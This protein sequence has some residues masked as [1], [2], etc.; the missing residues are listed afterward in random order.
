VGSTIVAVAESLQSDFW[1]RLIFWQRCGTVSLT[2]V[3]THTTLSNS[4]ETAK[5]RVDVTEQGSLVFDR[6]TKEK[7]CSKPLR[8]KFYNL[9]ADSE[10]SASTPQSPP[11]VSEPAEEGPA[12][13][14]SMG[15]AVETLEEGVAIV[16]GVMGESLPVKTV[17]Q[18]GFLASRAADEGSNTASNGAAEASSGAVINGRWEPLVAS[19]VGSSGSGSSSDTSNVTSNGSVATAGGYALNPMSGASFVVLAVGAASVTLE[20]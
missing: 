3:M 18:R 17:Q 4:V 5:N 10:Y 13:Q 1:F 2:D 15:S 16:E 9:K 14:E 12:S 8:F 6:A 20:R 11:L 19:I 7:S